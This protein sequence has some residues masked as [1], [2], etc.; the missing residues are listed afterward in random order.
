M[1]LRFNHIDLNLR[2]AFT[3]ARGSSTVRPSIQVEIE[4]D[5][6]VGR[7]EAAPIQRYLESA[8]SVKHFLYS[9]DFAGFNSPF[10]IDEILSYVDMRAPGNHSAKTAIDIALYDWIGIYLKLPIWKYFGLNSAKAPATSFTIGIDS[11]DVVRQK[12]LEAEDYPSLKVKVGTDRDEETMATIRSVTDKPIRADANEGWTNREEAV[13]KIEW[14][15]GLGVEF[16]E[17]PMP[18]LQIDDIRWLHERV[19]IPLIADESIGRLDDLASLQGAFDGINIKL[20]KCGGI[21]NTMRLIHAARALNM[22]VM[23]GCMI[24]STVGIAAAAQISPLVDFADLDGALLTD[25]DPY[26]G[27]SFDHG[28]IVLNNLPGLG[29]F[30]IGSEAD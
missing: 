21:R 25:N 15:S 10:Q 5:G 13:R 26:T 22:K 16:I 9:L 24:E 7:G 20:M 2:H 28:R 4:H 1:L 12:V 18:A 3:I 29:V 19:E 30:P 17:Q 8:E 23:L 6:I 11:P 14:L 27:L